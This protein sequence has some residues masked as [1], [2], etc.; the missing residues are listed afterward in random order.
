MRTLAHPTPPLETPCA[1]YLRT[2]D[3][4]LLIFSVCAPMRTPPSPKNFLGCANWPPL[5]KKRAHVCFLLKTCWNF[6]KN[7]YSR[8]PNR[9]VGWNKGVGGKIAGNLINKLDG[10]KEL[11]GNCTKA[12]NELVRNFSNFI[13]LKIENHFNS[14][15][16]IGNWTDLQKIDK[17]Q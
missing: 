5:K 13:T 7:H 15:S 10:I 3:P 14:T 12:K 9:R 16:I 1:P 2:Q 4:P 17:I 11:V 8:V 6:I